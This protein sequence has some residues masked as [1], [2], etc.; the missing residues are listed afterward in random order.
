MEWHPAE[1]YGRRGQH[2]AQVKNTVVAA[3][4]EVRDRLLAAKQRLDLSG[5]NF[6]ADPECVVV[7]QGV[8]RSQVST[9]DTKRGKEMKKSTGKDVERKRHTQRKKREHEWGKM[10]GQRG[11][12]IVVV[13]GWDFWGGTGGSVGV[14][15]LRCQLCHA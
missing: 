9:R 2:Q 12:T 15:S 8:H 3:A 1:K 5:H 13:F 7:R 4:V 10:G 14:C 6:E 11:G